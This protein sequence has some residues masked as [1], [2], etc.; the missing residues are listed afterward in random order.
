MKFTQTYRM[1]MRAKKP[2]C[3]LCSIV[4][5]TAGTYLNKTT[6]TCKDCP[7]GTYQEF[8]AQENCSMCPQRTSTT[9]SRTDNS[10]SCSGNTAQTS[11]TWH[12]K[13]EFAEKLN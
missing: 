12:A 4:N 8:D 10:S 3:I 6:G 13:S 7:I 5:C 9:E 11:F 2:L 1:S